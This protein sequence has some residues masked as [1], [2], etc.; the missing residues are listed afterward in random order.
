MLSMQEKG[1][2]NF[3]QG[4]LELAKEIALD[5]LPISNSAEQKKRHERELLDLANRYYHLKALRA[6]DEEAFQEALRTEV[7]LEHL[8]I[9]MPL[10]KSGTSHADIQ[11]AQDQLQELKGKFAHYGG[12][13]YFS[14]G[15]KLRKK[16]GYE[17][18]KSHAADLLLEGEGN[19]TAY[20][21]LSLIVL[22]SLWPQLKLDFEL[23]DYNGT[24]HICLIAH[25]HIFGDPV[26]IDI[27]A[28]DA[29]SAQRFPQDTP[30]WLLL[31]AYMQAHKLVD[32]EPKTSK[33][34]NKTPTK[35]K[36][37]DFQLSLNPIYTDAEFSL[38]PQGPLRDEASGK[39]TKHSK[40]L[41]QFILQSFR[42]LY[43]LALINLPFALKATFLLA[44]EQLQGPEVKTE[45]TSTQPNR[46]AN[47]AEQFTWV[48]GPAS[49][50][51]T[52]PSK[53]E[54]EHAKALT[55]ARSEER[56]RQDLIKSIR[57]IRSDLFFIG[58]VPIQLHREY[59]GKKL[60]DRSLEELKETHS[61]LSSKSSIIQFF[62][63]IF[64]FEAVL[65]MNRRKNGKSANPIHRLLDLLRRKRL[66]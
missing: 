6:Q 66:N 36:A 49:S 12:N 30:E 2:P 10:L 19:C 21:H 65:L 9:T 15:T 17:P 59:F 54:L 48:P 35:F 8:L 55:E 41:D 16:Y 60:E 40:L 29:K 7:D 28:M 47:Y 42:V 5:F 46:T 58:D 62:L 22:R 50:G 23:W 14:L 64:I 4:K 44:K 45:F 43:F 61:K 3:H 37:T 13:L 51:F 34:K 20:S 57:E 39:E 11:R 63:G 53:E 38:E 56:Q 31:E 32:A 33:S 52:L 25:D 27:G 18:S 24:A 26:Y 1:E